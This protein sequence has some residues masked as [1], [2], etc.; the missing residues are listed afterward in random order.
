MDPNRAIAW[1]RFSWS[2]L[3]E[4]LMQIWFNTILTYCTILLWCIYFKKVQETQ[5]NNQKITLATDSK[6]PAS[7]LK[8]SRKFPLF[9]E[10]SLSSCLLNAK[11]WRNKNLKHSS[12]YVKRRL[13]KVLY[14]VV[15][16]SIDSFINAF[17][18]T[19][20]SYFS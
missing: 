17:G 6:F 1:F 11:P 15:F 9:S 2:R 3:I 20:M 7:Q 10:P 14:S 8:S 19:N 18:V 16:E 12:D 13:Y 5:I 4:A